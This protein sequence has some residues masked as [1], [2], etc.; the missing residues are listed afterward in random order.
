MKSHN[1]HPR[2]SRLHR[3]FPAAFL[4]AGLLGGACSAGNYEQPSTSAAVSN[5]AD[6]NI[7]ISTPEKNPL[8]GEV[9]STAKCLAGEVLATSPFSGFFLGCTNDDIRICGVTHCCRRRR[10]LVI[11]GTTCTT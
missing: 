4:V 6:P 1:S 10:L 3:A 2:D 11:A 7:I 9:A 8:N 5:P